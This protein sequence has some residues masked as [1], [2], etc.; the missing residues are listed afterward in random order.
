MNTINEIRG[1]DNACKYVKK[2]LELALHGELY[3]ISNQIH[4]SISLIWL[5]PETDKRNAL[6][7][8]LYDLSKE[9]G[10]MLDT[11][12]KNYKEEWEVK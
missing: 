4:K 6:K 2:E 11:E 8:R 10:E 3:D 1:N 12:L 7:D 5:L 9:V